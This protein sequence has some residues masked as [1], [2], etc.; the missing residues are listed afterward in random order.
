M[1]TEP[2][3][4]DLSGR[5]AKRLLISFRSRRSCHRVG[6]QDGRP[7]AALLVPCPPLPSQSCLPPSILLLLLCS[8]LV[9]RRPHRRSVAAADAAPP[10]SFFLLGHLGRRRVGGAL[11]L[12]PPPARCISPSRSSPGLLKNRLYFMTRPRR[13]ACPPSPPFPPLPTKPNPS[14]GHRTPARRP[15]RQPATLLT[16][17]A[18]GP[19]PLPLPSTTIPV[20]HHPSLRARGP[21]SHTPP[22]MTMMMIWLLL[23]PAP[24]HR[25][26]G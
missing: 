14:K 4:H 20:G 11:T 21:H 13:A 6:P 16:A 19:S 3:Y 7:V 24:R 15:A 1:S 26:R 5:L 17:T 10:S 22:L 18:G 9:S 25:A 12:L 2:S 8:A 23:W